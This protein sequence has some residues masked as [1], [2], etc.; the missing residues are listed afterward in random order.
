MN[1]KWAEFVVGVVM[2]SSPWVFGFSD[3]TL[4][5]WCNVLIGLLLIL[6]SAWVI[7]GERPA[8]VPIEEG[9]I[10]GK[11]KTKNNVEK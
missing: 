11:Q 5:K 6:M 10:K 2:I 7:F 3:I 9:S 8:T 4:A 1:V